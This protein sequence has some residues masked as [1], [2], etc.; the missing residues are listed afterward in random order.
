MSIKFIYGTMS[1]GKTVQLIKTFEMFGRK[2]DN[3]IIIKPNVDDREGIFNGWGTTKSKLMD[4][5]V[6]VYYYCDIKEI[7]DRKNGIILIDEAQFMSKND[8]KFLIDY[9]YK[10]K[11]NVIAYGLKTDVNGNLFEGS[12]TWLAMADE[13]KEIEN[14]CEISGCNC[15]ANYHNRYINGELDTNKDIVVI[16]KG[17]V[18]YKS[19]C[20]KHWA[21]GYE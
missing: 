19:V 8:I 16:D 18:T 1:A 10:K 17:N 6:P 15:K 11:L 13:I 9:A 4:K 12:A 7:Q 2:G 21:K 14:I 3:P 5:I 20:Y